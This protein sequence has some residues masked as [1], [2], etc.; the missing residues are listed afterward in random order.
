MK[1]NS[2]RGAIGMRESRVALRALVFF[3]AALLFLSGTRTMAQAT[4][5][6]TGVVT[7]PSGAVVA[8]ANVN[9]ADSS[10]GFTAST[11]TNSAGIYQFQQ[12]P[13]GAHYVL[14]FSKANFRTVIIADVALAVGTKETKDAKLDL[15]DTKTT[16]EVKSE[17]E[18]SLN[19]TDASIGTVIDGDR[20]QDLPS[21][22]VSNAAALLQLAPGVVTGTNDDSQAGVVTGTRG[23]QANITLDGLDINDNRIGQAFVTVINT[24]LDSIQELKTTVGGNDASYGH[25][26]GG[27]V[28][29]VTKSGT[30]SFHGQAY[31]FNRVSAL[32]ANNFFNNLNGIPRPQLIRN[33]FGGD[34]GGPIVKDKLFFF[35]TY[36][37]LR[38]IQSQEINDVVPMA[39]V[40]N[41]QLNYVNDNAGCGAAS[42]TVSAPQCISTTPLTGPNSLTALDPQG[43][44]ANQALL[45]FFKSRPYPA[46][47]NNTVGDLVNTA[48]F[49]FTAPVHSKDNTFLGKVD[50]QLSKNHRLFAR[51]TWD[52]SNDDDF[53]NHVIQVFPG[54]S[55][56]LA[57]I[58]DHSRSWVVGDTWTVS[59]TMSNVVSF[60]ETNQVLV[61]PLNQ[62]PNFPNL[63]GFFF[64]GN[65]ITAPFVDGAPTGPVPGSTS[66]NEQFPIVPVYQLRDTYTWV[67][68]RHTLQFGGVIKPTIFKSGNLTDFNNYNVGLGGGLQSLTANLRP[69]DINGSSVALGEWD[70]LFPLALGR[71][72]SFTAG[73]N[74]DK[75]GNPIPQGTI[76]IRDYHA[77]EYEFFAQDT[78][79]IRSDLTV[80]YGLRW[81][82]HNP[83]T[84][85]N[86]FEAIPNQSAESVF[87]VRM[88]NAA[89][90]IE[91]ADAAPLISYGL[92]G[93]ANHAPGYYQPS[94][95]NFAPRL[96]IAY[97]P[98]KTQG[99]LGHLLG[100][101]KSSIRAGFG[102]NYDVNLIG[103]GFELD[104]TS[105]LFS[106]SFGVQGNSLATDPRFTGYATLPP[107]PAPGQS[108]RPTFTPNLDANGIPI[109]FNT[110]GF[111]P[112]NVTL[113]NFDPHYKTPYEMSFN[114]S[115]QRELPG[116]WLLDV[117]Y[118]GKLGRRLTAV[119]D[120]AQTLNV[121]DAT[122]GQFLYTAFGNVQQQLQAG[123]Q[124]GA[125][126]AQPWFEN[127]MSASAAAFGFT[128][129]ALS[130]FFFGP[131]TNLNCTNLAAGLE[132][133]VWTN[134]DVSSTLLGIANINAGNPAQG[135]LPLNS[136]LLAQNGAAAFIGNFSSSN[137]NALLLRLNHRLSHGLAL[138]FDYAY[139]HSIDNDSD[140][141]N[142]LINFSS[143][144]QAEVCDLRNLRVCRGN[145][146]FDARHVASAN[147][148]YALPFGRGQTFGHDSG[149][150]LDEVIGGW[151]VS[152]IVIAHSGFPIKVDTNT[153]PIDFTQSAPAVFVGTQSDVKGGIHEVTVGGQTTLQYFSSETNAL[154]AFAFPFGGATGDRNVIRGPHYV[155]TDL[156]ILKDFKMPWAES[157]SLQFRAEAFNLFNHPNFNPPSTNIGTPGN[158]GNLNSTVND[159]RQ[160]QLALVYRF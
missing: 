69:S 15:G 133:G 98:S 20:V 9:L 95:K 96:G 157:H 2:S 44:G 114:L 51:G 141:Q 103:Q 12:I 72:S 127:Q 63:L 78:W 91:G 111:G 18:V 123:V 155:N 106:N 26:A 97:S 144:G 45:S 128:C 73:F 105:F 79:N 49:Q 153:F 145:S 115:V 53:T 10:T 1:K 25:S 74:F 77:T 22:F 148:E 134:G 40:L 27:Q 146:N 139:S 143:A 70:T 86:G 60:G 19:T 47:N 50:Y 94:Y 54:D 104:E 150:L 135:L 156:A 121:K 24:P 28:E 136:G 159:A 117:G 107:P 11:T 118:F 52:R 100:D 119:G 154:G 64:N 109:G 108:P 65:I 124:P 80:T 126:T 43:M 30:N 36:N 61:F 81:E 5:S 138:E 76:P 116:N 14:T 42:N 56:P 35:F 110:G 112:G 102:I 158:F 129:P 33:Q 151:K 92:G 132:Q 39:Q 122:S 34:I 7:D 13:P 89:A 149:R 88:A 75:A 32:A 3:A 59:P 29:L 113:F 131:G 48:G 17:G 83:L 46:P 67:R 87:S 38:A 71:I 8:G 152:S 142:N 66:F 99:I 37:G 57:S 93:S 125:L 23:D 6:V 137:Y 120:V 21:L 82:F 85:V 16:I 140:I 68:N 55:A 84:E 130:N 31:D 101:R 147:F 41:G 90:G 160:W 4:S 62:K 58:I